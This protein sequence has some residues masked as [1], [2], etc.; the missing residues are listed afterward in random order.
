M[1]HDVGCRSRGDP[2]ARCGT[3]RGAQGGDRQPDH[4]RTRQA[5]H[6]ISRRGRD[7]RRDLRVEC[8]RGAPRLW[9]RDPVAQ[10]WHPADRDPRTARSHRRLCAVECTGHHTGAQNLKRAGG[11]L[12]GRHQAGGGDASHGARHRRRAGRRWSS[13]GRAQCGIRQSRADFAEAARVAGHP[14][15]DLHGFDRG[16][17]SS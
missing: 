17:A 2:A 12:F 9:S 7:R 13:S 5:D 3:D 4:A 16:R 11:W 15:P 1:A 14:R 6:R 10:P 8:G